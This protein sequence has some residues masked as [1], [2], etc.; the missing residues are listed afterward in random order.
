M[1]KHACLLVVY[2]QTRLESETDQG[3]QISLWNQQQL[4]AN[5]S[6]NKSS[7]TYAASNL[8]GWLNQG[9]LVEH[10]E[11]KTAKLSC[12]VFH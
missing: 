10:G 8:P 1:A 3:S 9:T 12:S 2:I 4:S 11:H 5:I 6:G 7:N